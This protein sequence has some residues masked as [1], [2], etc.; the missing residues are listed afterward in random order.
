M[1]ID[2]IWTGLGLRCVKSSLPK[3]NKNVF[4]N[5]EVWHLFEFGMK[6]F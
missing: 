4:L 6:E 5:Q 3:S 2:K 1:A